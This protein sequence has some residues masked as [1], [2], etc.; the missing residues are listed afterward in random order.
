MLKLEQWPKDKVPPGAISR[1]EDVEGRRARTKLYAGEPILENKLLGKGRQRA[2]RHGLDPQ[3]LSRRAGQGRSGQ[4]RQQPDPA[5]RPRRRDGPPGARP[6][7]RNSARRSRGR[8]CKTSRSS[9]STTSWTWRRRRTASKSIAAKTISLLVTPE[10]AAK[11]MLASQMGTIQSGDAQSGG[12]PAVGRTPRPGRANCSA[13]APRRSG[14]RKPS[15]T[16][17]TQRRA[18]RRGFSIS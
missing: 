5:R 2:G 14:A 4:R 16:R 18:K 3:G 10:Q 17:P 6:E 7:P 1:I 9:P 11:V 12:R 8:F 15:W 13:R